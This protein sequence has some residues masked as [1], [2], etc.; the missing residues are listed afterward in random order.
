MTT[1][2]DDNLLMVPVARAAEMLS[3]SKSLVY[4]LINAGEIRAVRQRSRLMVPVAALHEY[5]ENLP[6]VV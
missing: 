4:G 5:V 6:A 1:V 3:S 2:T